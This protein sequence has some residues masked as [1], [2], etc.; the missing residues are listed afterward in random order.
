MRIADDKIDEVRNANDIVEVISGYVQLKKRGKNYLGL[1]PFHTEKTP[2]FTVSAEKQMYHCFGCSKGGNIFTFLM[3]MD[4][5]SFV[6]AVRSLASKAGINIPEE[7]VSAT[8]EQSEFE[9][10][11]AVC[12]FAGMH[13]FR[14]LTESEEGKEALQYFYKRGFTDETIRTFGLGYAMN[15]WDA[16]IIKAQAEGFKPE[17]IAK[18]GLARVREDGSLYDYFRGRAMFPIFS[19]QGRVIGFGARKMRE[20]DAIAGKYINSPESPLYDKSRVLYGLFHSKDFIRQEDNALMVEGYADLISL[21]QAGIQNV[22][23][24]SGTALT[25]AQLKVIGRY[26]KNLTLVYDADSAGSSATVRGI[27]LA[28][29]HDLNVRIVELPEGEDPDSF[30]LKHGGIEFRERLAN[31]VSFIDFKAKQFQRSGAFATAEGKT[32]AVRSLVRSIAKMKDEL[33]RNFYVK[34]VAEKYEVYENL[35]YRELERSLAQEKRTTRSDSI[36]KSTFVQYQP[37][38]DRILVPEMKSIPPEEHDILKLILEGDSDVIRYLLSNISLVQFSDE[39]MRRLAQFIL[40][41]YDDRGTI[42]ATTIINEVQESEFKNLISDLVLSHYELSRGWQAME[43]EI[44]EAEP[45]RIA[46]D[47]VVTIQR[48]SIQKER[49]ENLQ[50]L[51]KAKLQGLEVKSFQQRAIELNELLNQ[52]TAHRS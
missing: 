34:E 47:A 35:L 45:M 30:V 21:Y 42:D 12:R 1:C 25:D 19:I 3:E 48:K 23:A 43:K 5:I 7:N 26:S 29:E 33:K 40:D 4:K 13:F 46:K 38:A 41:L 27:D 44:D 15:S 17:D 36:P 50:L 2:S 28:L 39:R 14:N 51:E 31:A 8:E 52:L 11:Y 24:S 6:E 32:Q 37:K 9:N 20:D 22:V 49:E 10:Y 18:V 16:F